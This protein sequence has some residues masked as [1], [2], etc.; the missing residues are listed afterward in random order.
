MISM[1]FH[2]KS[3]PFV[4]NFTQPPGHQATTH[5]FG[6][7]KISSLT[8]TKTHE[9]A[10]Q[11]LRGLF[12]S[13]SRFF[14]SAGSI[15]SIGSSGFFL[16]VRSG[17]FIGSILSILSI[18]SIL[19]ILSILS[20]RHLE[21]FHSIRSSHFDLKIIL[22]VLPRFGPGTF[23]VRSRHNIHYTTGTLI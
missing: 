17:G 21:N 5:P 7:L 6:L 23:G 11:I 13:F 16:S 15:G 1:Q 8:P 3:N 10:T 22:M 14:L 20:I 12:I 18:F 2:E 9:S 19:S 4:Y